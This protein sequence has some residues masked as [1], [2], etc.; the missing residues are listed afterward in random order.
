ML[1]R[2]FAGTAIAAALLTGTGLSAQSEPA[3]D[4]N[5]VVTGQR[6]PPTDREVT[7]QARNISIIGSP[8]DNPLPR[9]EERV[10]PGVLGIKDDDAAYIIQRIR[11]NAEQFD[12][13]LHKDDGKCE[14]NFIVAFVEDAQGQMAQLARRQGYMLAGL[15]VD[16]RG[17]LVDAPG[18]AR[19]W[20]NT[21][22]RTNTGAPMPQRRE[23]TTAPERTFSFNPDNGEAARMSLPPEA[24]GANSH[25]RISFPFRED[26]YSVLILFDR[27]QVKGKSL[28]QLAD[29]ATMRGLAFTRETRGEPEAATILSL[30]DGDGPKPERLTAFDLAYLGSLYDGIPNIPAQSKIGGVRRHMERQAEIA[31]RDGE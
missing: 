28:L 8:L 9:F 22:L 30:F 19:V 31:A 27:E 14:P 13:R 17:E 29:Y 6:E 3:D 5:I 11:H 12:V 23:T 2:A 24:R 18:A 16:V 4:P 21:V 10:C 25:S 1:P 26:I 7:E 15:S 20:T